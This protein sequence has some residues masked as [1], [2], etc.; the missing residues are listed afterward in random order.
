MD[1]YQEKLRLEKEAL[2]SDSY[3]KETIGY[4]FSELK[5]S[6]DKR[7]RKGL[8]DFLKTVASLKDGKT[9]S[10]EDFDSEALLEWAN[11][12]ERQGEQ[13]NV[14]PKFK[15][16]DVISDGF[17]TVT[18]NDIDED[19]YIISNGETENDSN[20]VNWIIHFEDQDKWKLIDSKYL[21]SY[22]T[23]R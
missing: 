18:I 6:E 21:K 4:I 1:D 23:K 19:S 17:S 7:I 5:G 2:D 9:I 8:I 14:E 10:N 13:K 16:G 15:I 20:V 3:D 22:D 11:W 12:L